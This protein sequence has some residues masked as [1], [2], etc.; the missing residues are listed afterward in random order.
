ML[1]VLN[2]NVIEG[3]LSVV[4]SAPRILFMRAFTGLFKGR[5]SGLNAVSIVR[6]MPHF[7]H[8]RDAIN[9]AIR[10]DYAAAWEY[11]AVRWRGLGSQ[12]DGCAHVLH[13]WA[14]SEGVWLENKLK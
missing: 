14:E 5:P 1:D 11:A 13:V 7:V 12:G 6:S 10:E 8:L 4:Q 2:T 9:T 3:I